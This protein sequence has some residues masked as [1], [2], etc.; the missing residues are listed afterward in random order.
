LTEIAEITGIPTDVIIGPSKERGACYARMIFYLRA[1]NVAGIS[2]TE[3]GRL[4]GRTHVAVVQA[5]NRA[6]V[7]GKGL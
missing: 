1:H 3:L 4:T 5:L 7:K 6:R 2:V